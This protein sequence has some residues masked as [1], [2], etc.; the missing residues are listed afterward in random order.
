LHVVT[1]LAPRRADWD[2][3]KAFARHIAE[4]LVAKHPHNYI[5][6]MS[7]AARTGKIF[8]DYFRNDR[9]ATAIAP[10]STRAREGAPVSVPL[11]WRELS[12]ALRSDHFT[13]ANVLSRLQSQSRDPWAEIDKIKQRL[14]TKY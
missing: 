14:P 9:G 4:G 3:V 11:A 8:I 7:K 6:T 13:V 1:P 10:Y 5:A 2:A 12:P